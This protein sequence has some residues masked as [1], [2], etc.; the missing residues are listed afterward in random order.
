MMGWTL[1]R[2]GEVKPGPSQGHVEEGK[3]QEGHL[4]G[5]IKWNTYF[6]CFFID[7]KSLC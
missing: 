2:S 6:W 3:G 1:A 5:K 7:S 4:G